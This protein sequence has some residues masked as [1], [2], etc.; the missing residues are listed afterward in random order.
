M[1]EV[2]S[3]NQNT[4]PSGDQINQKP[5]PQ[6]PIRRSTQ[7]ANQLALTDEWNKLSIASGLVFVISIVAFGMAISMSGRATRDMGMVIGIAGLIGIPISGVLAFIARFVSRKGKGRWISG[8]VL[9]FV[10]L[11]ILGI[12]R[13][14]L[15]R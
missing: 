3:P 4:Q 11:A 7:R 2:Q 15:F 8:V 14:I 5:K 10:I 12:L 9:I 6:R 13:K 1:N